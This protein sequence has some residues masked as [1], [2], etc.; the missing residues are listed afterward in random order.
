MASVN[1]A[2][3]FVMQINK[4]TVGMVPLNAF[5]AA[6]EERTL[7]QARISRKNIH[8]STRAFTTPH[9]DHLSGHCSSTYH[10]AIVRTR[11][12]GCHPSDDT[13]C[14]T[15]VSSLEPAN[16]EALLINES[17]NPCLQNYVLPL[18]M[19]PLLV[20]PGELGRLRRPTCPNTQTINASWRMLTRRSSHI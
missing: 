14:S 5:T 16:A 20:R 19:I 3:M 10:L 18:R 9:F 15:R 17:K 2:R 7:L 6:F 4:Q 12:V 13:P 1:T 11:G 8:R